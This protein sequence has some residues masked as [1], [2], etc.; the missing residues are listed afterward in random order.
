MNRATQA[1]LEHELAARFGEDALR[2]GGAQEP[3]LHD[4]TEMQG[5]HGRAAAVLAPAGSE[6][7]QEAVAWCYERG[8][9]NR[10][11]R[12][13][14]RVRGGRGAHRGFGGGV[15]GAPEPDPPPRP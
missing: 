15:A 5:L 12:G 14:D 11:P 3:Y 4:S 2:R 10:A 1:A 8:D 6:Q 13:R 9:R 7:V